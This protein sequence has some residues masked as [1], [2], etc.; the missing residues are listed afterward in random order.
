MFKMVP[1]LAALLFF[2]TACWGSGIIGANVGCVES[3]NLLSRL[4]IFVEIVV[5][6]KIRIRIIVTARQSRRW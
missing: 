5:F 4:L 1:L 2:E 6:V 3:I